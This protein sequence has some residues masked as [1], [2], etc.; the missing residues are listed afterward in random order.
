MR[1]LGSFFDFLSNNSDYC[2]NEIQRAIAKDKSVAKNEIDKSAKNI[3]FQISSVMSLFFIK[4]ISSSLGNEKLSE[5]YAKLLKNN[6]IS[7][8]ELIDMSIKLDF[9]NGIP[10]DEINKL[11]NKF[12]GHAIS[13]I[14]LRML[15]VDYIYMF[16]TDDA[17][18]VKICQILKI[19]VK[20]Q[21][22]ISAI[23]SK[24]N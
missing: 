6:P 21:R 20:D 8:Y 23:S 22:I 14:V 5:T 1:T 10:F 15:V 7:S 18:R 3:L 4:K 19:P 13:S 2:I 17:D 16:P 24:S 12:N 9:K 11:N